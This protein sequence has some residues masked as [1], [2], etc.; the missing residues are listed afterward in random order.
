MEHEHGTRGGKDGQRNG[1]TAKSQQREYPPQRARP[2][3]I[4]HIP[5]VLI[6]GQWHNWHF[7]FVVE[8]ANLPQMS[9]ALEIR[10]LLNYINISR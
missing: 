1:S 4:H 9:V 5:S 6:S 3:E 2:K 10:K 7:C 8:T